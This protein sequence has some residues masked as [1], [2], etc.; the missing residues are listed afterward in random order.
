MYYKCNQKEPNMPDNPKISEAQ[1]AVMKVLW[2][3]SPA[4][5]N[6]VVTTL[7]RITSWKPKTIRTLINRLV[8]KKALGFEKKGRVY[9]YYPVY[10]EADC[11]KA[12]T[13]SFLTKAGSSALKPMLAAFLEDQQLTPQEIAELKKILEKKE[14]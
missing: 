1:W 7:T 11:L 9:H 10:S 2:D 4:T 6:D 14:R 3:E 13:E 5:A 12:E 8:E